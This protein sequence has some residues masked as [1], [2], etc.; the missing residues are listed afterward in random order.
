M[1]LL[2]L[3]ARGAWIEICSVGVDGIAQKSLPARGAWIE[4]ENIN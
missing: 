4:I 2:S 1:F 3:P